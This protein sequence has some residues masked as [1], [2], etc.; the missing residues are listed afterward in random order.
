MLR[1]D[2]TAAL[3]EPIDIHFSRDVVLEPYRDDEHEADDERRAREIMNVFG[4]LR[5]AAERVRANYRQEQ[6]FSKSNVQPRQPEGDE[7]HG[8]Q[9]VRKS[10]EDAEAMH[11]FSGSA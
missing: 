6:N 9:P 10:F 4:G 7:G 8:H 11:L 5:E 2:E 3:L 1:L